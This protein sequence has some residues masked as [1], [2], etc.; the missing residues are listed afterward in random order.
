MAGNCRAC[1]LEVQHLE[2]PVA[3]CI[4]DVEPNLK[5]WTENIFSRKARENVME[6]LLLNHPLDCPIC[7]QA[8]ECDLQEQ[9]KRVGTT[10]SRFFFPKRSVLDKNLNFFIKTIMT[11]CIHCTRCVRFNDLLDNEYLGV[12][13]R[14]TSTEISN[15]S[16]N[17]QE[18]ELSGNVIDLC[19]VGALT[20]RTYAFQTRP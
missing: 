17:L 4:T 15:Y 20:G 18:S 13:N 7:D 14:G 12:L 9:S 10:S 1:L 3:A 16:A 8:G 5:I 6:A 11:R 19:P 2:K